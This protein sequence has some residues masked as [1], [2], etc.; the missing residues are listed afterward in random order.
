MN[1]PSE[2]NIIKS[3]GKLENKV[4]KNQKILEN[5]RREKV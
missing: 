3:A 5:K 4:K 2:K 1:I